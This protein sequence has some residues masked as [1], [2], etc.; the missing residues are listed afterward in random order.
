MPGLDMKTE[1]NFLVL[2]AV[3]LKEVL[4]GS[5]VPKK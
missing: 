5:S 1:D 4:R 2:A 3:R